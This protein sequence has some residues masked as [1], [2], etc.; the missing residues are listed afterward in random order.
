L[1]H[2]CRIRVKTELVIA[3]P[4]HIRPGQQMLAR[5]T[6]VVDECS[7]CAVVYENVASRRSHNLG[8]SARNILR[9]EH[10][11]AAG[12][13]PNQHRPTGDLVF[14]PICQRHQAT[15]GASCSSSLGFGLRDFPECRRIHRLY[16]L[17]AAAASI[18]DEQKFLAG[19]LDFVTV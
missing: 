9:A 18:V 19:D 10:D 1:C 17:C 3:T 16:V 2:L 7:V 12:I 11:I 5:H 15:T 4:N 13:T 6:L 14:P 8:M